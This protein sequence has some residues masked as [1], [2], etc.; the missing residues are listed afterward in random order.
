M[1]LCIYH[2]TCFDGYGAAWAVRKAK[3]DT[4]FVAGVYGA[5]PPDV[6]DKDVVLVDFSYKQ[7]VLAKMIRDCKSLLVLDHHKTAEEDLAFLPHPDESNHP[8]KAS[9]V[10]DMQ[11]S[12][13]MLA[14]A[15]FHGDADPPQL[16]RHI[17]DRD[18]WR[19][20]LP[21]TREIQAALSIVSV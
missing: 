12:G 13:A 16:L 19:F 7:P 17:E 21:N 3:P 14:W 15:Y 8:H 4:E 2:G 6:T 11:H 10:F 18:L 9:A 5:E 20:A 1:S